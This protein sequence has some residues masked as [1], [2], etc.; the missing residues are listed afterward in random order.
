[1]IKQIIDYI[2]NELKSVG[3][4]KKGSNFYL[5]KE[6]N[7]GL[8]NIQKSIR[9]DKVQM[10]FTINV[11]VYS[12]KLRLFFSGS[13]VDHPIIN[14]CCWKM[15]VGLLRSEKNDFWW[16]VD[17]D[18]DVIDLGL[19]VKRTINE[20][21]IPTILKNISDEMLIRT[22]LGGDYLNAETIVGMY[23]NLSALLCIYSDN[24]LEGVM[25]KFYEY[26][27]KNRYQHI[28]IA[29]QERIAEWKVSHNNK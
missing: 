21:V 25:E 4:K 3:F 15:R 5:F 26:C 12:S 7:I 29:Q 11:G 8:L 1:M 9:N 6:G 13:E 28:F 10:R 17:S 14:D 16:I 23:C 2:G 19:D 20:S 27:S 22:W 18:T 24:R